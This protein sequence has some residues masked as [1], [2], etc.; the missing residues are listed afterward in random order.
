MRWKV[1]LLFLRRDGIDDAGLEQRLAAEAARLESATTA[2]LSF[3]R[4][5]AIAD[6]ELLHIA[7]GGFD[8]AD[9]PFDAMMEVIVPEPA[10]D[11]VINLLAGLGERLTDIVDPE[12]SSVLVGTEHVILPGSGPIMVLIA[13]GGSSSRPSFWYA[14]PPATIETTIRNQ[15]KDRC[16]SA[17][18][19]ML[20]DVIG[21]SSQGSTGH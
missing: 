4:G 10:L 15:T 13:N 2:P 17:H 11:E 14:R 6:E 20:K 16:P 19:E 5:Y 12:A 1:K 3:C 8:A 9:R 21:A 7:A 18:S